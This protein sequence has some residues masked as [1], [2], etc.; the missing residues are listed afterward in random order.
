[1]LKRSYHLRARS[2]AQ[3]SKR[4]EYGEVTLNTK[5]AP[6]WLPVSL[7]VRD[8]SDVGSVSTYRYSRMDCFPLLMLIISATLTSRLAR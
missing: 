2:R 7:N 1:L 6:L 8:Y 4:V 3:N 5:R